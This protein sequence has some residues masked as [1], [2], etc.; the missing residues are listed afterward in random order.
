MTVFE[1][2]FLDLA[3]KR[4]AVNAEKAGSA[5]LVAR[6]MVHGAF[7]EAP[8]EFC[9]RLTKQNSAI[10][11]LPDERFQLILHDDF[12]RIPLG[13]RAAA[14]PLQKSYSSS[15]PVNRL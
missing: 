6:R 2:V 3:A 11:H 13:G 9:K 10:H 14:K 12:L 1:F 8:F 4:V 15:R 7:D 5:G